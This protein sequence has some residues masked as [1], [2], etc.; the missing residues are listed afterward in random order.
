VSGSGYDNESFY[1]ENEWIEDGEYT[2]TIHDSYGDG[3][4]C[5]YGSGSYSVLLDGVQV[6]PAENSGSF[7]SSES[8]SFGEDATLLDPSSSP[9]KKPSSSS[10]IHSFQLDLWT[11]RYAAETSWDLRDSSGSVVV[12][13]S[14]YDNESFYTENECIDDGEYTFTIYDSY[15]DGVCC[16]YGSGSYSVL[17]DEVQV[18]QENSGSFASSESTSFGGDARTLLELS[19]SRSFPVPVLS[20]STTSQSSSTWT[21]IF[22]NDFENG[23]GNFNDGG[24]G[25][26]MNSRWSHGNGSYSAKIRNDLNEKSNIYSDPFPVLNYSTIKVEFWYLS[27]GFDYNNDESFYLETDAT[28]SDNWSTV[29]TWIHGEKAFASNAEWRYASVDVPVSSSDLQIRFRNNGDTRHEQLFIDE[30]VVS[31]KR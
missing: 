31:G 1:T 4:C 17:F 26:F 16:G 11:D 7:A 13:G 24:K 29:Y 8:T 9:S 18:T 6:T 25:A 3:I 28:G 21:E 15:G 22:S 27:R 10:C 2:F 23:W 12:A 14:D 19:S 20:P 30:V 5:G